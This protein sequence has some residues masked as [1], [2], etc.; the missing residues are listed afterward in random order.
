MCKFLQLFEIAKLFLKFCRQRCVFIE[1]SAPS[2]LLVSGHKWVTGLAFVRLEYKFQATV[3]TEYPDVMRVSYPVCNVE[4]QN[5]GV[6]SLL[7]HAESGQACFV[8]ILRYKHF[9]Q[10]RLATLCGVIQTLYFPKWNSVIFLY[11]WYSQLA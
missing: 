2:S 1:L 3:I 4:R 8:K 7:K 6:G 10:I 9:K 5:N 11:F